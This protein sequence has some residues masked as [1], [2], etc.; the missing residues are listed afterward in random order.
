VMQRTVLDFVLIGLAAVMLIY[1]IMAVQFHSL[2]QPLIILVTIPAALVGAVVLLAITRTGLNISAGMGSLTLIGIAINN[3]IVLLDYA[4]RQVG[5][6]RTIL[7]SLLSAA[8]VRL[9]P[10]L[11]TAATTIFALI[12]VAVNPAVGSRVFQP[13]AITV[14]GGLLSATVATLVLGPVLRTFLAHRRQPRRPGRLREDDS[15]GT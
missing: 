7:D 15:R 9:R 4:N 11:M 1:L 5:A 3:A 10:I 13:F 12:P 6:G 14:V 8:S 2:L